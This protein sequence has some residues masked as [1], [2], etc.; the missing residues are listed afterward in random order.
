MLTILTPTYNRAYTLGKVY[1]SLLHQTDKSFEW[2]IVDD[3]STDDT[4]Q[5][6]AK[7]LAKTDNPFVIRYY[8]QKNGG[9]HRAVNVAVSKAKYEFCFIVDS[10]DYLHKEAVGKI[11]KWIS[12]VGDN[13]QIAGVAGLKA[14]S[15]GKK[16]GGYP[17]L[18]AKANYI[19][20][21]NLERKKYNLL[22]DKAEIYRTEIL[23]KYPFPEIPNEKF[24]TEAVVWDKIAADGYYLRWYDEIIYYCEYIDDGLT[25]SGHKKY[26]NSFDGFTLYVKQII[27]LYDLADRVKAVSYYDKL[28]RMKG[29]SLATVS[30][31]LQ[32]SLAEVVLARVIRTGFDIA[33]GIFNRE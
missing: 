17:T 4:R 32:I 31:N 2:V 5:K 1:E 27:G 6:V 12:D 15:D 8:Q 33:T 11:M 29:M 24:M 30:S 28:A 18:E 19:E 23:K 13:K 20:A 26:L 9:K 7:W 10:D 14:Y 22:G 21:S 16:V 3:G 25:K